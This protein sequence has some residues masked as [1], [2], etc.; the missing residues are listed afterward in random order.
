[1]IINELTKEFVKAKQ[2][3]LRCCASYYNWL[4]QIFTEQIIF[5]NKKEH[6]EE[7][8]DT[9]AKGDV[10]VPTELETVMKQEAE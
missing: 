6:L 9:F 8:T 7:L 3:K 4:N 5:K 2:K 10:Y 1:M